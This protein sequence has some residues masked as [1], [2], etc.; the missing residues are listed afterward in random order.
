MCLHAAL[1]YELPRAV[2]QAGGSAKLEALLA[3]DAEEATPE[4]LRQRPKYYYYNQW[5]RER[6]AEHCGRELPEPVVL[7]MLDM[8]AGELDLILNYPT[9]AQQQASIAVVMPCARRAD[10]PRSQSMRTAARGFDTQRRWSEK[11]GSTPAVG[12]DA[13]IACSGPR[14]ARRLHAA[15]ARAIQSHE[16][17]AADVGPGGLHT[18]PGS[19]ART[20]YGNG[21][22]VHC[23]AA[24]L[25]QKAQVRAL[26]PGAVG[27]G[28]GGVAP[29][30]ILP[31]ENQILGIEAAP[32]VK[33]LLLTD[34]GDD[35][36][37]SS[38]DRAATAGVMRK[39]GNSAARQAQLKDTAAAAAAAA[40]M[41]EDRGTAESALVNED[42][43]VAPSVAGREIKSSC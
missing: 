43:T 12:A 28:M 29:G 26:K 9:A 31:S 14:A 17:A 32:T 41:S 6:I 34:G 18:V 39:A 27:L 20:A 19:S 11:A 16:T 40:S 1:L 10:G 21:C 15:R 23:E 3:H 37:A 4:F 30:E 5:M 7:K 22:A 36:E 35:G 33:P 25:S 42:L 8:E 13:H 38:H 2:S 24:Y